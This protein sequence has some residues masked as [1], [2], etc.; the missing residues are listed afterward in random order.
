MEKDK[1]IFSFRK[2]PV[3]ELP[4]GKKERKRKENRLWGANA[5]KM[6]RA[7]GMLLAAAFVFNT[8]PAS[9]LAVSASEQE[10]GLCEHHRSHTAECGYMEAQPCTHEHKV[11]DGGAGGEG[12]QGHDESCGYKEAQKCGYVCEICNG[13]EP[14]DTGE[15]TEDTDREETESEKPEN[16]DTSLCA[17]HREHTADC[18]YSEED[19]TPCGYECRICP[20]EALIAALP[21]AVTEDNRADAEARLQEILTLFSELT[22][23]EQGQMDISHCLKLQGQLDEASVAMPLAD[24]FTMNGDITINSGNVSQYDG[25]TLTGTSNR[26]YTLAIDGTTV[27]LTISGLDFTGGNAGTI[28]LKNGATLN[29]T[30][31]GSNRLEGGGTAAGIT[32]P[33]GCSLTI[34]GTDAASLTVFGGSG[35][36]GIGANYYAGSTAS[37]APNTVG[38]ITINGG[39]I[40]A[41][42]S[43]GGAGI[44]GTLLC[45]TGHIIINGGTITATGSSSTLTG[46]AAGI[47]GGYCGYLESITINGGTITAT[48]TST[49]AGIGAGNFSYYSRST[50]VQSKIPSLAIVQKVGKRTEASP[51][52]RA[53]ICRAAR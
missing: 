18:G 42:G 9:E 24:T 44:G 35:G 48:G 49:S 19:N 6:R 37:G 23:D 26:G 50:A 33:A 43:A 53:P 34:D 8:L 51:F 45:N 3:G 21:N 12:G 41:T 15:N 22:E 5:R 46:S 25:K 30:L 7:L 17:H 4:G 16:T 32:V 40:T 27:D 10:T 36:A 29:L 11:N 2:H 39:N 31:Q 14:E 20:I 13:T 28:V 47:G 52:R 1:G 38:T